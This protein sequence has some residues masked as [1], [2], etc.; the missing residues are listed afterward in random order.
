MSWKKN[1]THHNSMLSP[2][3]GREQKGDLKVRTSPED[4]K[5]PEKSLPRIRSVTLVRKAYEPQ[6]RVSKVCNKNWNSSRDSWAALAGRHPEF[7]MKDWVEAHYAVFSQL[8]TRKIKL[9]HYVAKAKIRRVWNVRMQ[10]SN[11]NHQVLSAELLPARQ[12]DEQ[13]CVQDERIRWG[14]ILPS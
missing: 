8:R 1:K 12:S 11:R 10:M 7:H 9:S 13:K 14:A 6:T 3:G 4:G 2:K 5:V